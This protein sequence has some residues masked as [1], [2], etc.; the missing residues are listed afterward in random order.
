[1]KLPFLKN[2][3]LPRIQTEPT[4]EKLING[5][6]SDHID[7]HC[8][9]ELMDA[10]ETKDVPKFRAALEALVLNCFENVEAED[11]A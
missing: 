3:R 11:G 8:A 4:E 7:D 10:T 2:R 6:A 5:S 1:M 9:T